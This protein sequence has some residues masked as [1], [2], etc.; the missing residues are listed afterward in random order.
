MT[1]VSSSY[2]LPKFEKNCFK[3]DYFIL[4]LFWVSK[5]RSVAQNEWK[6]HPYMYILLLIQKETS[7]SG[8]NWKKTKKIQKPKSC[9]QLP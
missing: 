2:L 7:S 6:K 3:A 1:N 5:S 4:P 8:K 9:R